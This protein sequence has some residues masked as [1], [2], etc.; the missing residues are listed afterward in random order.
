MPRPVRHAVP[1]A[2]DTAGEFWRGDDFTDLAA[3]LQELQPGGYP[4]DRVTQLACSV[5]S[6]TAFRVDAD[7]TEGSAR[8][9]CQNCRGEVFIADS[10]DYANVADFAECA[11]PCGGGSFMVG[12]GFALR[13]NGDVRWISIGLLCVEDGTLGACAD[14][15][16]SYSP[17]DHLLSSPPHPSH[18][19]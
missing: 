17:T 2:I 19:P 14:W 1:V 12:M 5:C 8:A 18:D 11:C 3:Y 9:R 13:E 7:D 16:I 10:A 15:K 6:Q 4:V